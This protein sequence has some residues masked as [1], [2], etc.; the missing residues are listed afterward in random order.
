MGKLFGT[1]VLIYRHWAIM[2]HSEDLFD[3]IAFGE[4]PY[5]KGQYSL[6]KGIT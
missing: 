4:V 5:T 1:F 6:P 2:D 3:I